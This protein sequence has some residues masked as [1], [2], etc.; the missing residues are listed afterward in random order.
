MRRMFPKHIGKLATLSAASLVIASQATFAAGNK[1]VDEFGFDA[2]DVSNDDRLSW[3]E[4]EHPYDDQLKQIGWTEET[5]FNQYDQNNDNFI[6]EDEYESFTSDLE[7]KVAG[8]KGRAESPRDTGL[9][10]DDRDDEGWLEFDDVD[11]NNDKSLGWNEINT[12]YSSQLSQAGWNKQHVYDRFDQNNDQALNQNEYLLLVT[13]LQNQTAQASGQQ[14]AQA[15]QQGNAQQQNQTQPT[16]TGN[17][18][19]ATMPVALITITTIENQP[20]NISLDDLEDRQ[21]V[22]LQGE[23]LGEVEDVVRATNGTQT[24]LVLGV[25]GFWDM[26]DKHV[27]VPLEELRLQGDQLV[28]QTDMDSKAV[29]DASQYGYQEENY[30]SLVEEYQ[31]GL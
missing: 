1:T 23:D 16:Q 5:V 13:D 4:L 22:N 31:A 15:Q 14:Q 6:N 11:G 3:A 21:V 24:G 27:F 30:I 2:V 19:A 8:T 7:N 29:Q 28:W 18:G 25:G 20:A 17:Q 26:F 12:A 9:V 10:A